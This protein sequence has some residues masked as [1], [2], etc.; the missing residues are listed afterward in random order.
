MLQI[1]L[2]ALCIAGLAFLVNRIA[3]REEPPADT[4]VCDVCGEKDC[5]CHK[6]KRG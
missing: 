2:F 3:K 5:I 4:Y 6:E 1:L